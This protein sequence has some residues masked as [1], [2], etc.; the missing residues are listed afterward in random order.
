LCLRLFSH[1]VFLDHLQPD[2]SA[3]FDTEAYPSI[4][5][6]TE[7]SFVTFANFGKGRCPTANRDFAVA[8]HDPEARATDAWHPVSLRQTEMVRVD[9]ESA[10][11][12][13]RPNPKW[14]SGQDCI[15]MDCDGPKVLLYLPV[16]VSSSIICASCF[17]YINIRY[18]LTRSKYLRVKIFQCKVL[19]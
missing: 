9:Y 5:G 19:S 2:V 8:G 10:I 4:Y 3:W 12:L 16:L 1:F 6:R 14:L 13:Q 17:A 11:Y 18:L 7:I 15:D